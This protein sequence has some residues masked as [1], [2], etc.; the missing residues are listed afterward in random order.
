[1]PM[2][3]TT[4]YITVAEAARLLKVSPSTI[5]RWIQAGRIPA[6][7]VGQRRVRIRKVDLSTVIR[8]IKEA[9]G[10]KSVKEERLTVHPLT[11]KQR[12]QALAAIAEAK[13][14]QAEL[15]ARRGGEPFPPSWE[16]LQELRDRRTRDLA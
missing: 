14:F 3:S 16:I 11:E 9:T 12:Q 4:E 1:M 6:Y 10:G 5:G 8:P 15:V 2:D 13:R 7:R